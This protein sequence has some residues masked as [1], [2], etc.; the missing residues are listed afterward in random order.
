MKIKYT[1]IV[2]K[3]PDAHPTPMAPIV[4][5]TANQSSGT[6]RKALLP[7]QTMNKLIIVIFLPK[8][9]HINPL[10]KMPGN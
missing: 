8:Y 5:L 4:S 9:L 10:S 2:A 6:I 1:H 3:A 7:P